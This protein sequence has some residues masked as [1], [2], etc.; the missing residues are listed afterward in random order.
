MISAQNTS[1]VTT[2]RDPTTQPPPVARGWLSAGT[3]T[4]GQP[5]WIT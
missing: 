5:W 2:A 3:R 4:W 1:N